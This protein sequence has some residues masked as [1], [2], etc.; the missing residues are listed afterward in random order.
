MTFPCR[1][2]SWT[3]ASRLDHF[4]KKKAKHENH[5]DQSG[6]FESWLRNRTM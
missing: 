4:T 1:K 6:G 5:N 3:L 2:Q